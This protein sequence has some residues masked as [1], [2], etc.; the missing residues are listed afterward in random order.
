ML[1]GSI[2]PLVTP[3]RDGAVDVEGLA[4][5]VEFQIAGGSHGVSV[6]GTTGEPTSLSPD[7]RELVIATAVR[8]ARGRVP[9][10]AGSG[11]V[12]HDE[13]LR[14]MRYAR[15]IGADAALERYGVLE[16]A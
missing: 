13:T 3:F 1:R 12:N 16:A 11:S 14:F 5:L 9:V 4:R 15:D 7:E 8:A 10:L 6:C 2:V